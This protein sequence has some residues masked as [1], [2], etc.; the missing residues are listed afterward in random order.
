MGGLGLMNRI[1]LVLDLDETLIHEDGSHENLDFIDQ[2]LELGV[3][4]SIATRNDH[5][6]A[7]SRIQSLGILEKLDYVMSDFRPKSIQMR[8]ILWNYQI[9]GVSFNR[10]IFID[11]Y[12]PNIQRMKQDLPTV[13]CIQFGSDIK[14]FKE[15][16]NILRKH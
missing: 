12:G 15:L 4:I 13:E 2:L 14:C 16:F 7:E 10:I 5:Y 1:L 6:I 3:K 11:D 8:H 9:R